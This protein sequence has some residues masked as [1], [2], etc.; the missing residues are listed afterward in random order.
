MAIQL[1]KTR[2]VAS[3]ASCGVLITVLYVICNICGFHE[4]QSFNCGNTLYGPDYQLF[5]VY[6]KWWLD[7][8]KL[9]LLKNLTSHHTF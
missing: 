2:A 3:H 4:G 8:E 6:M 1:N 7:T 9:C 5:L